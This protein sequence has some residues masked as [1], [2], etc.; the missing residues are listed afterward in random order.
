MRRL[1]VVVLA[2]ALA[3]LGGPPA[4]AQQQ[5]GVAAAVRGQ[6]E[7]AERVGAVGRLVRSGEP[8][9]LGNAIR[10]GPDSGLQILLL[11][12][13]TFTI[14]PNSELTID[15]FVFD[16]ATSAGKV[17]ASVAKGV[18][19][20]V[21]GKVAQ[22]QPSN[23]QVKLP[24]GTIGIRGTIAIGRVDQTT[25]NGQPTDRQQVILVGP[26]Q[27]TEANR[28]GG[29]ELSANGSTTS[30]SKPGFGSTLLGRGQ[31]GPAERFDP[32]VIAEINGMLRKA[33]GPSQPG[34]GQQAGTGQG[35]G[36]AGQ[37]TYDAAQPVATLEQLVSG[38]ALSE[39]FVADASQP[40]GPQIVGGSVPDGIA[41]FDQLRAVPGGQFSY[42]Q[43]GVPVVN[44]GIVFGSYSINFDIDF[45]A[46]TVG[47]GGSRVDVNSPI[48]S[49]TV[50]LP[51]ISYAGSGG[52]AIFV[53]SGMT[54][55]TGNACGAACTTNL[56]AAPVNSGGLPASQLVHI[57]SVLNDD[58]EE[59]LFGA[60]I[61]GRQ[62]GATPN[63]FLVPNGPSTYD[64]LRVLNSGQ[65]YWGQ[66]NVAMSGG[67]FSSYNIFLDINFGART[68]GG[69]NSRLEL[70]NG[71]GGTVAL[72]TINYSALSGAAAFNFVDA[73]TITN[74]ACGTN[75]IVR[76]NTSPNNVG[77]IAGQTLS[78]AVTVRNTADTVTVAAGSGTTGP[79]FAGSVPGVP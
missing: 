44:D 21:T 47:G 71:T 55:V 13:T 46:R 36:N 22:Q 29:I 72:N 25:Q 77:G 69:G 57:L 34:E 23:M 16:P 3:A 6:V 32:A 33:I 2:G 27:N 66:S 31:W 60:G 28:S 4:A 50:L 37:S 11:D 65:F 49:G 61:A 76:V 35:I 41:T 39:L 12:Q 59:V 48:A 9:F 30:L 56:V 24:A 17:T 73:T 53:Y 14:G 40:S 67:A 75:C 26:G 42:A 15:E 38:L 64:H 10:S 18:F 58:T 74:G 70:D 8:V 68:V 54:G 5:A 78:H 19:R 1:Q 51:T 43:S 20:F 52:P 79:R 7:I 45:G 63:P 62:A